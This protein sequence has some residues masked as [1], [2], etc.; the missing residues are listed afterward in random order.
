MKHMPSYTAGTLCAVAVLSFAIAPRSLGQAASPPDTR[1]QAPE[2]TVQMSPF[3]VDS[4]QDQSTYRA[5]STLAG[6]RVRTDLKDIASSLSVVTSEFLRDTGAT[7]NQTL[8]PYVTNTEVG[9][10]YGNFGG[11][12][13]TFTNS[14]G[15][16]DIVHPTT[17]TRVRG[18]DSADNTRDYFLTDIPWDAF[19]V[20]RV[21]LQ[22]GPNSIL[23]GIGSPAG[24]INTS[25]NSATFNDAYKVENRYGSFGTVR[26]SLD[27]NHVLVKDTLAIRVA[28]LD[29]GTQYRQKPAFNHDKRLFGSVR[30]DP[31]LF[32]TPSAHTTI[33]VN[34]EHGE[35]TANRPRELPPTDLLTPFFYSLN[36]RT[37]DPYFVWHSGILASPNGATVP[38]AG[39]IPNYWLG[40]GVPGELGAGTPALFN[41]NRDSGAPISVVTPGGPSGQGAAT[42]YA[43]A[44]DGSRDSQIDGYP[45][46]PPFSITGF[47]QY[48]ILNNVYNPNDPNS[49]GAASGF[50]KDRSLADPSIF[51]FYNHLLGGANQRQW[52]GWDAYNLALEQTFL[53]NRLGLQVVYD[54]QNYH[55]GSVG[56]FGNFI[57]VDMLTNAFQAPWPY[58]TAVTSYNGSGTAGTNPNAGRPFVAGNGNNGGNSSKSSR[59]NLR[60]TGTGELRATDFLSKSWLSD[61]LGRHVFTGLYSKETYNREDRTWDLF[62]M[63]T[64]WPDSQGS[65]PKAGGANTISSGNRWIDIISYLGAPMFGASSASG[66]HLQPVTATYSPT[67]SATIS[68]FDSHWKPST[69]PADPTYVNPGAAWTNPTFLGNGGNNTAT[70]AS[71]QSENPANYVGW[72]SNTFNILNADRGDINSLYTT[73]NK[74]QTITESKAATWQGYLWDDTLAAT[75]GWRRDTQKQRSASAPVDVSTGVANMSYF[76]LPLDQ[77]TGVASGNSKSWGLVLHEPKFLRNKLPWGTNVSLTYN[78]GNNTRVENRYGFDG[79]SLPN[80]SGETK[81]YGFVLNTLDDRLTLKVTWYKTTVKNA[82]MSSNPGTSIFGGNAYELYK[83]NLWAAAGALTDLAGIAGQS[84]STQGYWDWAGDDGHFTLDPNNPSNPAWQNDPDTVKE[85]AAAQSFLSQLKPQAWWDAY[86]YPLNVTKAKAGDWNNAI[87][88]WNPADFIWGVSNGNNGLIHGSVPTGTIDDESKGVEI[89]LTGQVAKNWNVSINASKQTAEQVSI[90]SALSQFMASEYA[91]Y[92]TAAGDLRMWWGNDQTIRSV[93]QSSIYGTYQFLQGSNGRLVPEMAPWRLNAVTNYA[94]DR[95]L[96]KGVNVGLGYR[97]Q[98]GVILG[99]KLKAD[100]SNLDVDQPYWGK[101]TYAV[102]LWAGYEHKLSS[103]L[104]WRIQLNVRGVDSKAHLEPVSVEPDG[105]PALQRIVEGQTWQLTNTLSF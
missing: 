2:E 104:T 22:R 99:Y 60:V 32:N 92:Q 12:G 29:D 97:W 37:Y 20:D 64:N 83:L 11:V 27:F 41:Y 5:T 42:Y 34:F 14:A 68:T 10:I 89:E 40:Q 17:N 84:A 105:T 28:A 93:F 51:D 87:A 95:G 49:K 70:A 101:S 56:I 7:N 24:I 33:R 66:L 59:E 98:Q 45:F 102:D 44:P 79:T 6:T 52:Q 75:F 85:K 74:L 50:Y 73:G 90:G 31:N 25:V 13:N 46:A 4:T 72:T 94:F 65:G 58:S 26:D 55:D 62:D 43:L 47:A 3:V 53:D 54:H 39:Q 96:L 86:G 23:F 91:M 18:L 63:D 61:L 82:N 80:A 103:K 77:A 8:L 71:T 15:E 30:F 48:S 76:L 69:N 16:P 67:G 78:V 9:G 88:N 36:K 100:F 21:D 57:S 1:T 19:N 35:V 38:V 81:D